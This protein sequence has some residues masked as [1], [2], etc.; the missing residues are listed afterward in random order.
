MPHPTPFALARHSTLL[1]AAALLALAGCA[2]PSTP[3]TVA[4]R[5]AAEPSLSTLN[6]LVQQAGLTDTLNAAGPYTVFAPSNEAFRALP[7]QSLAELSADPAKLKAVLS[8]HVLP[9]AALAKDV[10]PG[11]AKTLNGAP[12]VLAKAGDFVTVDEAVVTRADLGASN[13]VVQVV[14]RVLMP[15]VKR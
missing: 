10:Q 7:A 4:S 15:P 9:V 1:A 14:D 12:L 5:I 3:V 6:G 2:T 13:G 8:Y 11:N